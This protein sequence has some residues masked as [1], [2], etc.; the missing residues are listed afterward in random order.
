STET[1]HPEAVVL[2][3]VT[4]PGKWQV[5]VDGGNSPRWRRDGRE[6]FFMAQISRGKMM[7][8]DVKSVGTSLEFGPPRALFDSDYVNLSAGHPYKT[9]AVTAD[10]QRFLIPR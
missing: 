6:L 3:F 1:G 2:P 10:G 9:Y 7:A 4:G 8:V 5:S